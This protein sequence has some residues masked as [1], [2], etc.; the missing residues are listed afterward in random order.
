MAGIAGTA[1]RSS[2]MAEQ[3]LDDEVEQIT[4]ALQES[5]PTSRDR[6]EPAVGGRSWGPGRFRRAL[7]E[8]ERESRAR[9]PAD[10]SYAPTDGRGRPDSASGDPHDQ[11]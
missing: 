3:R 4:H 11:R 2:A 1:S 5:G 8:S 7:R 9:S 6:L 10:G